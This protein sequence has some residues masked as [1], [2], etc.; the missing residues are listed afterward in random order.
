MKDAK[1]H[2]SNPRGGNGQ[3]QASTGVTRA[4]REIQAM[5]A[6]T[7]QRKLHAN[8]TSTRN[9]DP[10]TMHPAANPNQRGERIDVGN[11]APAHMRGVINATQGKTLAAVSALG[12]NQSQPL[13]TIK[14]S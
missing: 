14:G 13:P 3:F 4:A 9:I 8:R 2:G 7:D 12:T 1:G 11:I 5:R 10:A 6:V